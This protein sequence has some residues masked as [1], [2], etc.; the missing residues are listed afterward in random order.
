MFWVA[1]CQTRGLALQSLQLSDSSIVQFVHT[2]IP[3]KQRRRSRTR[4][5]LAAGMVRFFIAK[6]LSFGY[7]DSVCGSY[8]TLV[9]WAALLVVRPGPLAT[10]KWSGSRLASQR[11]YVPGVCYPITAAPW[12]GMR[13]NKTEKLEIIQEDQDAGWPS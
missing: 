8:Q 4:S 12:S 7:T 6:N 9:P 2:F 11:L 3:T 5:A 13:R 10:N 1:G